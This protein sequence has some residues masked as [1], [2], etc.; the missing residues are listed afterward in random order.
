M[1]LFSREENQIENQ[2]G[3][4]ENQNRHQSHPS[5]D[6]STLSNDPLRE[7]LFNHERGGE[8]GPEEQGPVG[9]SPDEINRKAQFFAR[10]FCGA[11]V[12]LSN[13]VASVRGDHCKLTPDELTKVEDA[14]L[15]VALKYARQVALPWWLE[16]YQEELSLAWVLGSVAYMKFELDRKVQEKRDREAERV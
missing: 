7:K 8:T 12:L 1:G 3:K 14:A 11:V 16:E 15:P 4:N 6:S 9:P 5:G 10:M 13:Q 2:N